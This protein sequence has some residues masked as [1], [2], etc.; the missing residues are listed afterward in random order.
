[1]IKTAK[2]LKC[3]EC[4]TFNDK[5]NAVYHNARYYCKICYDNQQKEANDYKELITY[6]CKLYNLEAPSG[7]I[8]KQIKDYKTQFNYSY[9]GIKTTLHYFFEIQ[10]NNDVEDCL[11][12]GIVP[13]VYDEAK[14]FYIDKKIVKD[15]IT[16]VDVNMIQNKKRT[17]NIKRD[18]EEKNQ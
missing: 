9:R 17:I 18:I 2:K 16:D 3:P 11:G 15:S 8:M 14:K 10:A 6:I 13:F 4:G 7:W 5:E 12:I 1:V